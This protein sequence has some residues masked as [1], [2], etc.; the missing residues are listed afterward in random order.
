MERP[1]SAS[2]EARRAT[3]NDALTS[4]H[5]L[6]LLRGGLERINPRELVDISRAIGRGEVETNPG[7]DAKFLEADAREVQRIGNVVDAITGEPRA[8]FARAPP[9]PVDPT[10]GKTSLTYDPKTRSPVWHTD[11]A[12]RDPPPY[13]SV[14][15]CKTAP[16]PGAGGAT[17]FADVTAAYAALPEDKRL[18][19]ERYRAVCSYAHHNAKVRKRGTP[20][21]PLLTP[22][23]RAEHPPVYQPLVLTNAATGEK[24]G[25]FFKSFS[26]I[27]RFQ[28]LIASPFN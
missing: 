23:Q 15:Y 10:C 1:F 22:E 16:P 4:S 21:Y 7:V 25:A 17:I 13:A 18:E 20:S 28:H 9:L 6:V 19:L 11:Q 12:F 14:L 2:P 3:L 27:A 24:S 8:M 26:P 5:G